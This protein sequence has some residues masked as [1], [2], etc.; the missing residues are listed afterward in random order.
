MRRLSTSFQRLLKNNVKRAIGG[1]VTVVS[2]AGV[3]SRGCYGDGMLRWSTRDSALCNVDSWY[4]T[5]SL[6]LVSASLLSRTLTDCVRGSYRTSNG[7][8]I[9][10]A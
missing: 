7:R 5:F 10:A 6:M 2:D 8:L 1:I 4:L 3:T 9:V